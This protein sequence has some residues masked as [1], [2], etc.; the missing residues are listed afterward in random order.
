MTDVHT[1]ITTNASVRSDLGAS[2]CYISHEPPTPDNCITIYPVGGFGPEPNSPKKQ[3]SSFQVRVRADT[4]PKSYNT[5]QTI[6]DR[7]HH[8]A[9]PCSSTHGRVYAKQSQPIFLFRD[10]DRRS[11]CVA[12]FDV[13]YVR[14]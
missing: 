12:N 11:I 2:R 10:E 3:N 14:Y 1:F 4:F 9:S 5:C 13:K 8:S 6:I 7:M